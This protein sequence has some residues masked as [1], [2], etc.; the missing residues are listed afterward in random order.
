MKDIVYWV[1]L[2]ERCG[3]GNA[4]FARLYSLYKNPVDIYNLDNDEVMQLD[5]S[6][7]STL[8]DN[9]C[10]RDLTKARSI[11]EYCEKS[12][13]EILTFRDPRYPDSL[14]L[15]SNP[16]TLL[17]CRGKIPNFNEKL[18]IGIVGTRKMSR[19]GREGAYR[20]AYELSSLNVCVV[21]GL[22]L[23]IDATAACG[24]I[25]GGELTVQVLG[26]GVDVI[27]PKTHA[28]LREAVIKNGVLISEYPPFETAKNFYFPQR[29]RIISGI[30]QGLFVAEC[31]LDSGAMITAKIAFAQ[32]KDLF[33]FPG[34]F[35]DPTAE[36]PN[37][38]L[39]KGAYA[40]LYT[41]D[42]I[43]KYN[44]FF[45]EYNKKETAQKLKEARE[46]APDVLKVLA[47]YSIPD[48][49]EENEKLNNVPVIGSKKK[50]TEE[51]QINAKKADA[52]EKTE[53]EEIVQLSAP[54]FEQTTQEPLRAPV[55]TAKDYGLDEVNARVFDAID[56]KSPV[57]LDA[58]VCEGLTTKDVV[59]ALTMLEIM[60]L[61][62]S[63]PGG[64]Y[65][66]K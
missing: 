53:E 64:L 10:D 13:I 45:N 2:A 62:T 15:I 11:C 7:P 6:F 16:P 22:A 52:A 3:Y 36:G 47:K 38:L 21:S 40:V 14:R 39:R 4:Y 8:K 41:E 19:Y 33:A 60:G 49:C 35:G 26:C 65:I 51:K 20:L 30:S 58:I 25:E 37:A 48:K 54:I 50:P 42:I 57:G 24:A 56:C 32:G 44:R 1:W 31:K 17:Y 59:T 18:C 29:N 23:G 63:L 5:K 27:Y 55:K 28:K 66:R 43:E 34:K 9:L 46:T 12:G 61:I